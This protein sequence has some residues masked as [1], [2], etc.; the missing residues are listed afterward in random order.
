MAQVAVYS[1]AAGLLQLTVCG[2]RGGGG[3]AGYED[4]LV[5]AANLNM[6]LWKY[7]HVNNSH[8]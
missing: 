2:C 8:V 5:T 1:V 7:S 3:G 4:I 6:M